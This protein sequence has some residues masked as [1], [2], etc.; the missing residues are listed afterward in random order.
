MSNNTKRTNKMWVQVWRRLM[1][2]KLAVL[3]LIVICIF[4]VIAILAPY[5][6]PYHYDEQDLSRAFLFPCKDHFL[7][8]D[9]FGRDILSR[10]IYGSRVSLTV[11]FIAVGI[12]VLVGGLLG[13]IAAF[14]GKKV[15]NLIM[16]A[17]DILLA[18]PGMLLAL[19]LASALGLAY[20]I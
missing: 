4:A 9:N 11:G 17:M 14:Y 8:T 12:A 10:I 20:G 5:I 2:N 15:D 6:A 7:G 19:A 1:K 18:I 16:R 3:G 13:A